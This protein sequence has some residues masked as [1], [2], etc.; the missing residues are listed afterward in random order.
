MD[1]RNITVLGWVRLIGLSPPFRDSNNIRATDWRENPPSLHLIHIIRAEKE[2][3]A[4]HSFLRNY[5]Y[6]YIF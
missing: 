6:N 4:L 1:S 5:T 2:Q 3:E